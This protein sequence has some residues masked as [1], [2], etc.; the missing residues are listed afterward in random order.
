MN[1]TLSLRRLTPRT[2]AISAAIVAVTALALSTYQVPV[3]A[4]LTG[5]TENDARV[6]E[7]VTLYL[8]RA[9]MT[10]HPLDDEIASRWLKNYL[11]AL[12]PM[13]AY[14]TQADV[15]DFKR[16]EKDLTKWVKT[17]DIKFAHDIYKVFLKRIAERQVLAQEFVDAKHDYAVDED[18]PR[19]GD[20]AHYAK[21]AADAR[22][23]W[24]KRV[25]FDL[26]VES[27]E[28]LDKKY[29]DMKAPE[30]AAKMAEAREKA[31]EKLKRRYSS[32]QK[33]MAQ[34]DSDEVLESYLTALTTSF[35]PHTTY[36][37]PST[38]DNFKI[39]M[40]LNLEGIG[41]A[42]KYDDGYTVVSDVVPGGAAGLDG[43]LKR[44][45]RI[46]GVG[47]ND[48]G[49][50]VDVVEMKLN[51][52]VKLIRGKGG[53]IV[54]LQV[55]P[56]GKK[57]RVIYKIT[58]A[59]I[60]L[61]GSE[62]RSEIVEAGRKP[63]GK[64]YKIGVINLPSF[65]MD[66]DAA[67]SGKKDYK[68][69]TRDIRKILEDPK[70]GFKANGVDVVMLDLRSNGGGSLPES[71]N[72]TGLFIDKGPVVQVKDS[73]GTV[74]SLDDEEEGTA[75]DGPLVVLTSMFSASASE[76]LAGAIQDYGRGLVIGDPHTH[77][78]GTVQSLMDL[79]RQVPKQF[80]NG[81][82]P[83]NL[84]ALK[85]TMQQFYR[86]NGDSTQ[87]R[88]VLADVEL[89]SLVSHMDVGEKNLDYAL[90]F[91]KVDSADYKKVNTLTS[92]IRDKLRLLS[93]GRVE[94]SE[95]FQKVVSNVEKYLARKD[96]KTV[97][98][99]EEKYRNERNS[100]EAE[101]KEQDEAEKENIYDRPVIDKNFYFNEAV[102]ITLDYMNLLR[103]VAR[104]K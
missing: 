80:W 62:A 57:E 39:S 59:K 103:T 36:M 71:I 86:P 37:S 29:H 61:K 35:D 41:A 54:R 9:H 16:S 24:R 38:L 85:I 10:K 95:D 13:K 45:D 28:Q 102:D 53:S 30:A 22:E 1:R 25:K 20:A 32:F 11:T 26:L 58:R 68:S 100:I 97:T 2:L 83:P 87:N 34:T 14:F 104:V 99:N 98:L 60:E 7:L 21:D 3:R 73:K 48:E 17:G 5:P 12:D 91:D 67:Q 52:V 65:Y 49:P 84:G 40:Q 31:K 93:T 81:A 19:V 56:A 6:A 69:S 72:L 75:W 43:R 15:D 44:D 82:A 94:K 63:D 76:I 47:Q 92:A 27:Y 96:R 4:E 88:G 90:A 74:E 51:D 50:I 79:G 33:R 55:E 66:M 23:I 78:K 18:M 46:V 89:P 70:T 64:P 8:Q 42:L 101:Q 77:G